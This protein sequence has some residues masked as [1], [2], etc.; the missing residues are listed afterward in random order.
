MKD[1]LKF[2]LKLLV[3]MMLVVSA[4]TSVTLYLA[5]KNLRQKHQE[6]LNVRFQ[7]EVR[8]FLALQETRLAA[9]NEKCKALSHSVRL[10]AALEERDVDD[11]YHNALAELRDLLAPNPAYPRGAATRASFVRFIDRDKHI[12]QFRRRA[13]EWT[14]SDLL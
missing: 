9:L 12:K 4:V 13:R 11:L 2:R 10:R 14:A 3:A 8:S 5:G 7:N 6:M 1:G